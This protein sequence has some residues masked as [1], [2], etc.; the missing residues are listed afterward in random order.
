MACMLKC[1][2]LKS[3]DVTTYFEMPQ[4]NK[5]RWINGWME[6]QVDKYVIKKNKMLIVESRWWEHGCSPYGSFNFLKGGLLG[7]VRKSSL[8]WD[9]WVSPMTTGGEAWKILLS[10]Q[11]EKYVLRTGV[12][13]TATKTISKKKKELLEGKSREESQRAGK[14]LSIP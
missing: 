6:R 3:A 2:G 8:T 5:I 4:E 10:N 1:W 12:K 9:G 7:N 13:K 11:K 14:S